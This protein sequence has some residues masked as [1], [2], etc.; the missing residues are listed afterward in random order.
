MDFDTKLP[1]A[2]S[3]ASGLLIEVDDAEPGRSC[4]CVCPSC[5]QGVVARQGQKNRWCFAHDKDSEHKPTKICEVSFYSCCRLFIIESVLGKKPEFIALPD[6]LIGEYR[7]DFSMVPLTDT[8][9]GGTFPVLEVRGSEAHD[10]HDFTLMLEGRTVDVFLSYPGRKKPGPPFSAA[11]IK[12]DLSILQKRYAETETGRYLFRGLVNE[13]FE[14]RY[15]AECIKW[16]YTPEEQ[17]IRDGLRE[18]LKNEVQFEQD[19]DEWRSQ[20]P[21]KLQPKNKAETLKCEDCGS[22]YY[23]GQPCV[24]CRRKKELH[25]I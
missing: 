3:L 15:S 13:I 16:L 17:A 8:L 23:P 2:V 5:R 22:E 11:A 4:N 1:F 7:K 18:R 20:L 21:T 9:S 24:K 6:Y 25:I 19:Y 14:E 12:I 10:S